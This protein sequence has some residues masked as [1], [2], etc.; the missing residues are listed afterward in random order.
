MDKA[1]A[2]PIASR[3]AAWSIALAFA[4]L[5]TS[6]GTTYFAIRAGVHTY[7]V[8]PA[9]FGGA[10]VALAGWLLLG[11]LALRGESIRLPARE[12]FWIVL[13]G[14]LLFVAG[15]GLITVALDR[16]PSGVAAV[17]TATTPLWMALMEAAW[18]WGEKLRLR[19]WF[20]LVAGL[21]GV[22]I[23]LAPKLRQEALLH[24]ASPLIA[25]AS[26]MLWGLGAFIV[27]H[28]PKS[29]SHLAAA[30]YQM[31]LGGTGLTVVGLAAGEYADLRPECFGLG[32]IAAFIYLLI[33]GSLIGFV[34][35]NWLLGHVPAAMVGTYAYVNPV[36][37]IL[38][39]RFLGG[40]EVTIAIV[41]GMGI[42]L[43]GVALV[44]G[45]ALNPRGPAHAGQLNEHKRISCV[46]D[47]SANGNVSPRSEPQVRR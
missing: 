9:L 28:R 31:A 38:V 18:P 3:P 12:M 34:A 44:R 40:E 15:N 25:L 30:A 32:P 35:F 23:L 10:R 29:G 1:V 14:A 8:P 47:A 43:G 37:A 16:I 45:A 13:S 27:R 21:V 4:L 26:T 17:L 42:I 22:L 33:V 11:Y 46:E 36:V 7:H 41:L 2:S 19:G 6:W 20:G 24:D 39:G 5:Y